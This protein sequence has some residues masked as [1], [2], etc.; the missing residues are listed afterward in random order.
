MKRVA[1]AKEKLPR[2][3]DLNLSFSLRANEASFHCAFSFARAVSRE[4]LSSTLRTI[5]ELES[6]S[7]SSS[8][9]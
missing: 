2:G 7:V 3:R 6:G 1:P 4:E 9:A 8:A 5:R